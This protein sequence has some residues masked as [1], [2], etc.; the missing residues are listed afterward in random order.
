VRCYVGNLMSQGWSGKGSLEPELPSS[1]HHSPLNWQRFTDKLVTLGLVAG[2]NYKQVNSVDSSVSLCS[3]RSEWIGSLPYRCFRSIL[4]YLELQWKPLK[5][6]LWKVTRG[7]WHDLRWCPDL[8]FD[9]TILCDEKLVSLFEFSWL[10]GHSCLE[11]LQV[12][13]VFLNM[14]NQPQ[15]QGSVSWW[16][17]SLEI[18]SYWFEFSSL[19]YIWGYSPVI[20]SKMT[21]LSDSNRKF[22]SK[23]N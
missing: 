15:A 11:G 12:I 16:G 10:Q 7:M 22:H 23:Q 14:E 18:E 9:D 3:F 19:L 17:Y 1:A 2:G 21:C 4:E 20:A 6:T 8:E 5:V 13:T